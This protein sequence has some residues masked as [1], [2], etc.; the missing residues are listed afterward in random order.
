MSPLIFNLDTRCWGIVSLKPRHLPRR[1]E[2]RFPLTLGG[3]VGILDAMDVLEKRKISYLCRDSNPVTKSLY[4]LH[5]AGCYAIDIMLKELRFKRYFRG[6]AVHL[7]YLKECCHHRFSKM[8]LVELYL[9]ACFSS[10]TFWFNREVIWELPFVLNLAW[11]VNKQVWLL[12][13]EHIEGHGSFN[14]PL[15]GEKEEEEK[16]AVGCQ[17]Q[18]AF[19]N[20]VCWFLAD[21]P[22]SVIG[23]IKTWNVVW[24]YD[25]VLMLNLF[26]ERIWLFCSLHNNCYKA[27]SFAIR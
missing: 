20:F 1:K 18:E 22:D 26:V 19:L 16:K 13:N 23:V 25:G 17:R 8:C 24:L 2:C 11:I 3:W 12:I 5:S 6:H 14:M 10:H 9:L 4:R 15:W 21:A 7:S 27:L